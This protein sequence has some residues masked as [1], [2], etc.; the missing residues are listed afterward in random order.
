LFVKKAN[1]GLQF[2]VD[3]QRLNTA[4]CK[5]R[6]LL[7]LLEETLGYINRTKIFTKL[8]ICQTFYQ[9][10]IDPASE[11]LITFRTR[12]S[13][14]KFKV[15]SFGLTNRPVTY[16]RY[17]NNIL[18]DYLDDFYTVYLDNILIYS[19][20]K[21]E[22]KEHIYKVLQQLIKAGLQTDIQKSEFSVKHTKYLGYIISTDSIETDLE[23]TSVINQ[24]KPPQSVK[25]IQSFLRFCGF[26]RCFIKDYRQVARLLN[27]L[28]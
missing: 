1:R 16:Q 13:C 26:Y 22:Y 17:I 2:C 4:I 3:Y 6:Y 19:E 10:Y 8:D 12:Y 25:E 28:T 20:N 7:L 21:L 27:H 24:W 14:F 11:D 23:K 18:F 15:V 5:D 9:I